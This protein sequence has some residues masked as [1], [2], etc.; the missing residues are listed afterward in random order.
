VFPDTLNAP[1]CFS[2]FAVGVKIAQMVCLEFSG[3][4]CRVGFR[5]RAMNWAA[6]PKATVNKNGYFSARE[7]YIGTPGT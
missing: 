1:A 6:V 7:N 5:K 4:P 2:Q 3:P